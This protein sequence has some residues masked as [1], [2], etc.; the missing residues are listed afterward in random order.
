MQ[1]PMSQWLLDTKCHT[2]FESIQDDFVRVGGSRTTM[3]VASRT[4]VSCSYKLA[5]ATDT[6][7]E[8]SRVRLRSIPHA[9]L[10]ILEHH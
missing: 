5:C 4:I 6:L 2:D 7:P 10:E 9:F 3:L 1:W 8:L